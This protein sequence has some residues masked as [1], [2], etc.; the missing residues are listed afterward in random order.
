MYIKLQGSNELLAFSGLSDRL[1]MPG[2]NDQQQGPQSKLP[3][4]PR[5]VEA[6]INAGGLTLGNSFCAHHCWIDAGH[7]WPTNDS[8]LSR[9]IVHFHIVVSLSFFRTIMNCNLRTIQPRAFAQNP[10][11][12]SMWVRCLLWACLS[13]WIIL[14]YFHALV[15]SAGQARFSAYCNSCVWWCNWQKDSPNESV[16]KSKYL[17]HCNEF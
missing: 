4:E 16:N 6:E 10:H 8:H 3:D 17:S 1:A 2:A 5:C 15:N 11:L 14:V 7:F 9:G 12:R 13:E